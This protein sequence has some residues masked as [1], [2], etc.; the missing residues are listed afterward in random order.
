MTKFGEGRLFA[1]VFPNPLDGKSKY[2][3]FRVANTKAGEAWGREIFYST[4]FLI[5]T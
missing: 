5:H 1:G 2:V 4:P 3:M